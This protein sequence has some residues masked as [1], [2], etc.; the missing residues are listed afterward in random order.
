VTWRLRAA[1][2]TTLRLQ[3]DGP[4]RARLVL[5]SRVRRGRSSVT[6]QLTILGS[7]RGVW[8]LSLTVGRY[9]IASDAVLTR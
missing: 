4:R 8:R 6:A 5:R 7:R 2:P 9:T 1:R 3:V